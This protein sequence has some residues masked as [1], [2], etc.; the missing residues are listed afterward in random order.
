ML[1]C[2]R[3][4][5]RRRRRGLAR[6]SLL[7][8]LGQA[9]ELYSKRVINAAQKDSLFSY[10]GIAS[11]YVAPLTAGGYR[12][13]SPFM[14][15]AGFE[16]MDVPTTTLQHAFEYMG[17][18][19]QDI[20]LAQQA[21]EVRSLQS[22]KQAYVQAALAAYEAGVLAD[23]D[24]QNVL[25]NAQYGKAATNYVMQTAYLKR[26]V[27][28]AADTETYIVPEVAGGLL[29]AE[30]GLDALEAAGVQ[31]WLAN[32]K[33]QL[34]STRAA[35][36]A[37][38][39]MLSAEAKLA[40]QRTR[41]A[42]KTAVEGFRTGSLPIAGLGAALIAAGV[43]PAIAALTV[44]SEQAVQ[45]GKLRLVYGQL[46]PPEQA[47]QLTDQVNA[48]GSQLRK[49]LISPAQ[50]TQLLANLKIDPVE[51]QALVASWSALPATA[52]PAGTLE[53]I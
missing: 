25:T 14:L 13:I 29:T 52:T 16:N 21:I 48:I 9:L 53:P 44:A 30:Q 11:G 6:R 37:N 4:S 51:A 27:K 17:L 15:S 41:A 2:G 34:A 1:T 45:N 47:R 10:A 18:R 43:D 12:A 31:P 19:P 24:I 35:L 23:T 28:L 3:Q 39:K 22:V 32:L 42:A 33:I 50:A 26:Q 38:K 40:N 20:P 49:M 8:T 7:P 46:L 5:A 36:N